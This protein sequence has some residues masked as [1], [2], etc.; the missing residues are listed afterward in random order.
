MREPPRR[1]SGS[2]ELL[3]DGG[4][5]G[6]VGPVGEVSVTFE[7]TGLSVWDRGGRALGRSRH[8]R[9][10]V[11]A[12]RQPCQWDAGAACRSSSAANVDRA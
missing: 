3:D 2:Q 6:E 9:D 10:T 5:H 1:R 8:H 4:E 11:G 12:D 7:H